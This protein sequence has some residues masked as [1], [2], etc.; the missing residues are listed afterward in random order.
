MKNADYKLFISVVILALFGCFMIYSSSNIWAKYKFDDSF[1]YVKQQILF[2]I[3]GLILI[4]VISKFDYKKY[5]SLANKILIV[6]FILLI[7]V[8]ISLILY[9]LI[10]IIKYI[11]KT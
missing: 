8:L 1:K 2:F 4:K 5:Y 6:C 7:L 10:D 9:Y 3:M 11:N